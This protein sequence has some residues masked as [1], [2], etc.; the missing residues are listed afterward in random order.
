MF[1][2]SANREESNA[3]KYQARKRKFGTD[4][5]LPLWVA[6]ME[7]NT[8]NFIVDALKKRLEHPIFGY[9]EMPNSAFEA[10][11]AWMKRQ[12]NLTLQREE[13]FF[14]PSVLTSLNLAIQTFSE[15]D[16]EIIVQPPVYPAFASSIKNNRRVVVE[17]P[18]CYNK[19]DYSF[20]F[21]DLKEKITPKTKLL[22]LCSPHNP[23]GR[24]WREEELLELAKIC[25][26]K[27]ILVVA[28]E[29]HG[30]LAFKK[31]T[32][33]ASFSNKIAQN[34]ITL[35][36]PAKTF[37]LSGLAIST[38]TVHSKEK[39]EQ[40]EQHY[41]ATHLGEG[42]ALA[43]VAFE[44]AYRHGEEWV[45]QLKEHLLENINALDN[46]LNTKT[47][48]ITFKKPEATFLLWLNCKELKKSDEE[49]MQFFIDHQLGLN[50]GVDFGKGGEGFMRLNV[51][52]SK[53]LNN[54]LI[55]KIKNILN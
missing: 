55:T 25:L 29:I 43:H 26:E 48:K 14:S 23:V 8:P 54:L 39:R 2:T 37:N 22:L 16:D 44:S 30:D 35:L 42:N 6:D 36:S 18:L 41:R 11:I 31:H 34:T 33:L 7:I 12:H 13:M 4:E 50:Q 9:E 40:F 28:D 46:I 27:N 45:K 49:L 19:G 17:N 52:L 38:I 15:M 24:V 51:G 10:Q 32:P 53:E 20:D 47:S 5:I 3:E 21:E 1:E